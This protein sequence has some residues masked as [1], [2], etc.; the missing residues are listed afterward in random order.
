[1]SQKT[2]LESRNISSSLNMQSVSKLL[3]CVCVCVYIP[4][5]YTYT[6]HYASHSQNRYYAHTRKIPLACSLIRSFI[7]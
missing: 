2:E 1:M 6:Y 7:A 3:V 4:D 5:C